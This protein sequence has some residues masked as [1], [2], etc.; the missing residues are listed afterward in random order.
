MREWLGVMAAS[1]AANAPGGW[2]DFAVYECYGCHHDLAAKLPSRRQQQGYRGVA[3]GLRVADWPRALV[4]LAIFHTAQ[5]PDAYKKQYQEFREKS[6]RI[7]SARQM[8]AFARQSP[9]A[10]E[11]AIGDLAQWL[12]RLAAEVE[13]SRFDRGATKRLLHRLSMLAEPEDAD[14]M[15]NPDYDTARQ[16]AWAMV[17]LY[18]DLE[19][20]GEK[21]REIE[22]LLS[23]IKNVVD[24]TLPG[25]KRLAAAYDPERFREPVRRLSL[26]LQP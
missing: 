16:I 18:K 11:S 21:D 7:S 14:S 20:L 9:K 5:N 8:N 10:E 26:L 4:K 22:K 25:Q 3:G 2:P 13:K 15:A 17:S 6:A 24:P 23:Q 1:A 19:S 12:N